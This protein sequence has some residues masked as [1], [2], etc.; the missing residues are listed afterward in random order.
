MPHPIL[1]GFSV[2]FAVFFAFF[3][4]N[5]L[6]Y[7]LWSG[8]EKGSFGKGS[9]REVHCLQILE[10]PQAVENKGRSNIYIYIYIHKKV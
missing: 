4:K 2:A 6:A 3:S 10:N 5:L 8:S 9:F 1:G 7:F